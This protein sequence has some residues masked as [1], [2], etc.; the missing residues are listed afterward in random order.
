[1]A[2]GF[3]GDVIEHFIAP[4]LGCTGVTSVF[5]YLLARGRQRRREHA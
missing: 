5:R 3:A 4:E 1:V 2:F